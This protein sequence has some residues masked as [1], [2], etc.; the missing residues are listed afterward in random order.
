MQNHAHL[1]FSALADGVFLG[2]L[3]CGNRGKLVKAVVKGAGGAAD[4][5]FGTFQINSN[6][7]TTSNPV[8]IYKVA[9]GKQVPFKVITPSAALVK[10]A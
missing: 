7:D 10:A 6:G 5:T 9:G 1:G 4:G 8:T 2:G 3:I